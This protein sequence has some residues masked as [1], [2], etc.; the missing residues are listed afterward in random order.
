VN[1]VRKKL[2][3][4]TND[5][6]QLIS[7][8][9]NLKS[10]ERLLKNQEATKLDNPLQN[11]RTDGID[12][13]AQM[14]IQNFKNKTKSSW[15]LTDVEEDDGFLG[16]LLVRNKVVEEPPTPQPSKKT[17]FALLAELKKQ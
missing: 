14:G 13:V 2:Q 4:D 3:K 1:A 11:I 8:I 9:D 5:E 6:K 12:K 15:N 17:G 7:F 10:K 16:D